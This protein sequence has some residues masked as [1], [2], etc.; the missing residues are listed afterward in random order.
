M[1]EVRAALLGIMGDASVRP[2]CLLLT[3]PTGAPAPPRYTLPCLNLQHFFL[4][5]ERA[6]FENHT[7]PFYPNP[8]YTGAGKTAAIHCLANEL[9]CEV[10]EWMS[11]A[12][13]SS[14]AYDYDGMSGWA[15]RPPWSCGVVL[16]LALT[17]A[18]NLRTLSFGAGTEFH[19]SV[20]DK[21]QVRSL[22]RRGAA[23]HKR[24]NAA[25]CPRSAY[26]GR[27]SFCCALSA[28]PR[29]PSIRARGRRPSKG[30]SSL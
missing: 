28:T 24:V 25:H 2:R 27:R 12:H 13:L 5:V 19:E 3:G 7:Q 26:S 23:G 11:P 14:F 21:F 17:L 10:S 15:P 6:S 16:R 1:E 30:A 4:G 18:H 8:M 9:Q 22:L 20:R 29:L